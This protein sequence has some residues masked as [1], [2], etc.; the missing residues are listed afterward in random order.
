MTGKLQDNELQLLDDKCKWH[1][2]WCFVFLIMQEILIFNKYFN[3][4][5]FKRY[6]S[7]EYHINLKGMTNVHMDAMIK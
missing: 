1:T 6:L 7:G 5:Y 4:M 3:F 2:E